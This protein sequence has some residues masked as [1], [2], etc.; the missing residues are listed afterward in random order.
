MVGVGATDYYKRGTSPLSS[1]QLVLQ[2]ILRA[3]EDAGADP[4]AI[5]GFVSYA[6][7]SSEGLAIGRGPGRA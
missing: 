1:A 7:D 3:C 6:G 4:R 5:D 2:A